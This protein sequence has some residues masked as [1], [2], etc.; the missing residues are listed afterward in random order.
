VN[1][2]LSVS[3]LAHGRSGVEVRKSGNAE[4]PNLPEAIATGS[5]WISET[6]GQQLEALRLSLSTTSSIPT[7]H[8]NDDCIWG[9]RLEDASPKRRRIAFS[10]EQSLDDDGVD[11]P[12]RDK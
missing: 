6:P 8:G 12:G 7:W 4:D 3:G 10:Q 5:S 11:H 9:S 1:R 2:L